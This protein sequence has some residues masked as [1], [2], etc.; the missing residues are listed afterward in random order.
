MEWVKTT[1][2]LILKPDDYLEKIVATFG[3]WTYPALFAV[4]F[5]ETGLVVLPLL[6]GDSLLFGVGALAAN[7]NFN[8]NLYWLIGLLIAA[9][10]A[11]DAVNYYLGL[12]FGERFFRSDTSRLFNK[13]YLIRT[14]QFYAKYGGKTIILARFIPIIRTFAPFVA[15]MGK[16]QYRRFAIYNVLGGAVWVTSFLLAGYFLGQFEIIKKNIIFVAVAIVIISVMPPVIECVLTRLRQP[17]PEPAVAETKSL[18]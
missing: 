3:F 18:V 17:K 9:A 6:P 13:K 15:G 12:R 4:I 2:E 1:I 11:G 10:I 8:L 5:C 7:E 14:Q 16:M